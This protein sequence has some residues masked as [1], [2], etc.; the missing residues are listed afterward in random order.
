M[1]RNRIFMGA[2]LLLPLVVPGVASASSISYPT[3]YSFNLS[4]GSQTVNLSQFND[5][6]GSLTLT[7]V[8]LDLDGDIH[9]SIEAENDDPTLP[10]SM[11]VSLIGNFDGKVMNGLTELLHAAGSITDTHGPVSV[12][13]TDGIV[14]SGPDYH[15]YGTLNDSDSDSDSLTSGLSYFIGAGTIP[16]DITGSGGYNVS[17]TSKSTVWVTDFGISGTAMVTYEYTP[18]PATMALL[19]LGALGLAARRRRSR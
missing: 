4:P 13:A 18:E 5:L 19:G 15:D 3:T 12:T 10:A 17:G 14:R 16:V 6:G 11:G 8:T 1:W 2:V 9:S 7:K